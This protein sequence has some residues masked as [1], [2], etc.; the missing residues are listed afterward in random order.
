METSWS[1]GS[2][3]KGSFRSITP[4]PGDAV[5]EKDLENLASCGET[6]HCLRQHHH[7]V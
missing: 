1:F 3:A 4:T 2:S 5:V 7:L 6:S